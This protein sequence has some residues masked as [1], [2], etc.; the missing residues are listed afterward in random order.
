ML[1]M[2]KLRHLLHVISC[3]LLVACCMGGLKV[4]RNDFIYIIFI[5]LHRVVKDGFKVI[6]SQNGLFRILENWCSLFHLPPLSSNE[7]EQVSL[8]NSDFAMLLLLV[9]TCMVWVT[10]KFPFFVN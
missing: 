3:M 9:N 2:Q 6:G 4:L 10:K 1:C 7:V 8:L 5:V